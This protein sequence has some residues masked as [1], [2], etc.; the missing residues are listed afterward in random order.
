MKRGS[1]AA[2]YRGFSRVNLE[3]FSRSENFLFN[4]FC[5]TTFLPV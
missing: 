3:T 1:I 2:T 5:P 4:L